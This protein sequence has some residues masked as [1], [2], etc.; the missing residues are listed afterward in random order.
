M[1]ERYHTA[2]TDHPASASSAQRRSVHLRGH[3]RAGLKVTIQLEMAK[4]YLQLLGTP[5]ELDTYL[6][7]VFFPLEV[8]T[9]QARVFPLLTHR[10]SNFHMEHV[11]QPSDNLD[12]IV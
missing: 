2:Y 5:K 8:T 11:F 6:L 1:R 7:Q 10:A 3:D 4:N 12:K 9:V